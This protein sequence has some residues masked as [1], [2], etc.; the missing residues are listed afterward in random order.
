[1]ANQEEGSILKALDVAK[2]QWYHF[3]AVVV[4]GMGFFTDSYD[5]FVI[6]LITKLLGR[7]NYQ[8]PGSSSPGTLPD[9]ISAAVRGVAFAG[10]F[11]G[12]IFFG[13]LGDKLGRKRV[14]GSTLLIMTICSIASGLSFGKDPKTVMVTLCFFRFWLGFGIGGDYPLS[15]TIMSEYANKR[16]RGAFIAS[17]FAMQGVENLPQE[18]FLYM[19]RIFSR[20]SFRLGPIYWTAQPPP[21]HRQI[22]CGGSS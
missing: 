17:V 13:C 10:T 21:S 14:Y 22:T 3:T 1:M 9:G 8:V 11:L 4:A 7:I 20:L 18:G 5:L 2:T 6:S 16:T 12:Q 19:S 15:A